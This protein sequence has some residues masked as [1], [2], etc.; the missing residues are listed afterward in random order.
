MNILTLAPTSIINSSP[1]N[2]IFWPLVERKKSFAFT[3]FFYLIFSLIIFVIKATLAKI[4]FTALL[5]S[6]LATC[7]VLANKGNWGSK[8]WTAWHYIWERLTETNMDEQVFA[9]Y[10]SS[11]T[12]KKNSWDLDVSRLICMFCHLENQDSRILFFDRTHIIMKIFF[13]RTLRTFLIRV[14]LLVWYLHKKI[15]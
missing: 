3:D 7:I 2:L 14:F 13:K 15:L 10:I 1:Q 4:G 11:Y 6:I 9:L 5:K 8:T 12:Q